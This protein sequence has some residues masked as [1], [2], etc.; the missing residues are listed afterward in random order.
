MHTPDGQIPWDAIVGEQV[1]ARMRLAMAAPDLYDLT[2]GHLAAGDEQIAAAAARL[3]HPLDAQHEAL[4]RRVNGWPDF[5]LDLDLLP[6]DELGQG[7]RHDHATELLDLSYLEADVTDAPPREE[8]LPLAVSRDQIDVMAIATTG[9]LTEGGHRV[10]WFAPGVIQVWDN[11]YEWWLAAIE[12]TNQDLEE[13][14]TE[15]GGLF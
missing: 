3:G 8:I 4:L 5:L 15:R 14:I 9:P 7:P 1:L 6:T 13:L 2:A 12:M 11:V 10:Y